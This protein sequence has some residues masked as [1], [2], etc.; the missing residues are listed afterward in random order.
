M[1]CLTPYGSNAKLSTLVNLYQ[2][3]QTT[4]N[5]PIYAKLDDLHQ[6]ACLTYVVLWVLVAL[7]FVCFIAFSTQGNLVGSYECIFFVF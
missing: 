4:S 7:T 5:Y 1:F 6:T 2:T 3:F